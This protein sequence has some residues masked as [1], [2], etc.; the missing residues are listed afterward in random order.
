MVFFGRGVFFLD[1]V[2]LVCFFWGD[3]WCFFGEEG[4]VF[5]FW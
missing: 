1:G 4:C 2:F 5:L 3:E